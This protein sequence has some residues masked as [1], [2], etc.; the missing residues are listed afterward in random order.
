MEK[1]FDTKNRWGFKKLIKNIQRAFRIAQ[2]TN[3]PNPALPVPQIPSR[4][5]S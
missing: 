4:I 1:K 5:F 3:I 2:P